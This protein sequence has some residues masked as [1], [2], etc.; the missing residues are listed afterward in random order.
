[1][2]VIIVLIELKQHDNLI[3]LLKHLFLFYQAIYDVV[4]AQ[5]EELLLVFH[6]QLNC[7]NNLIKIIPI[8]Y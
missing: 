7:L 2:I 5:L 3:E 6:Y 1:M 8:L 4:K